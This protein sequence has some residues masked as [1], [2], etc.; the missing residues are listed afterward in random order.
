M[1]AQDIG[2]WKAKLWPCGNDATSDATE[3]ATGADAEVHDLCCGMGG[4]SFYLPAGLKVTGVDLDKNRLAMYSHNMQAFGKA[5]EIKLEA[6]K[7]SVFI[8]KLTSK[9]FNVC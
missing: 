2:R 4:D 5:A 1:T 9:D 8:L 6:H 7:N 3:N